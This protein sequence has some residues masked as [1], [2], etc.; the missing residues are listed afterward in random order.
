MVQIFFF[1]SMLTKAVLMIQLFWYLEDSHREEERIS[2]SR[3]LARSVRQSNAAA[4]SGNHRTVEAEISAGFETYRILRDISKKQISSNPSS[5]RFYD[6]GTEAEAS[7][8]FSSS[9]QQ[10]QCA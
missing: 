9:M 6:V 8:V 3:N 1:L 2:R 5:I 4:F 7:L 10:D